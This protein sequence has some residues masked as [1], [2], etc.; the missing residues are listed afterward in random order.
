MGSN[1]YVNWR[2]EIGFAIE[3][4]SALP[5]MESSYHFDLADHVGDVVGTV[6]NEIIHSSAVGEAGAGDRIEPAQES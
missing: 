2:L 3:S 6:H 4:G 5:L 1:V